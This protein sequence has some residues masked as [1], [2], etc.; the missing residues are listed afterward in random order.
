[1]GS[2]VFEVLSGASQLLVGRAHI[3]NIS[4]LAPNRPISG[5]V[6]YISFALYDQ[7]YI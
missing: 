7:L 3:T 1:M 2:L 4:S 5:H 6:S